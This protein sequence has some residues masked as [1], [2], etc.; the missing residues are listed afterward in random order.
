MHDQAADMI[1]EKLQNDCI[2]NSH[3][4]NANGERIFPNKSWRDIPGLSNVHPDN[5]DDFLFGTMDAE[6]HPP[7][8][9]LTS[10][11]DDDFSVGS[12]TEKL[13]GATKTN[14]LGSPK[15]RPSVEQQ[16]KEMAAVED[17]QSQ[18]VVSYETF[19]EMFKTYT[20]DAIA[21]GLNSPDGKKKKSKKTTDTSDMQLPVAP[22]ELDHQSSKSALSPGSPVPGNA[23]QSVDIVA[24]M[25][26]ADGHFG[27]FL[28]LQANEAKPSRK[29][30]STSA[31]ESLTK[32]RKIRLIP[33]V[34][35]SALDISHIRSIRKNGGFSNAFA[36]MA[37]YKDEMK[38]GAEVASASAGDDSSDESED[39]SEVERK[40]GVLVEENE[41]VNGKKSTST[42][43]HKRVTKPRSAG[44]ASSTTEEKICPLQERI[45][46]V[47]DALQLSTMTRIMFMHKYSS[48]LYA[49]ELAVA[50]D[51]WGEIAVLAICR[52]ET[53]KLL[54]KLQYGYCVM[55]LHHKV[56]LEAIA[57]EINPVL[58]SNDPEYMPKINPV[59]AELEGEI[60]SVAVNENGE[61][62]EKLR[63]ISFPYESYI[64]VRAMI[65]NTYMLVEDNPD[66]P[67]DPSSPEWD[68][69]SELLDESEEPGVGAAT[70]KQ[71]HA[72]LSYIA[73]EID[74]YIVTSL[75]KA[76]DELDDIVC[77][78]NV[79]C[80]EWLM[81][82]QSK[83]KPTEK[84]V[85]KKS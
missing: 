77:Y 15:P 65:R 43:K 11:L 45:Q 20:S 76:S 67:F 33:P 6:S 50:V 73:N 75:K 70:E 66:V 60:S 83:N 40:G 64:H 68:E 26:S 16:W 47:H 2:F 21:D 85:V 56:L 31:S 69:Y 18:K 54:S 10:L 34:G 12:K 29:L 41:D 17:M 37:H 53:A 58:I 7:N 13:E 51:I 78:G 62:E 25:K 5:D 39:V 32:P 84:K 44:V 61:P 23:V 52:N 35:K 63:P 55:P 48:A 14:F 46:A 1:L 82:L 36:D 8:P 30:I 49:R 42:K 74:R 24:A 57:A 80:R 28:K 22:P 59:L 72:N 71:N 79:T 27:N 9:N 4:M 38:S 81:S 19:Q 3:T